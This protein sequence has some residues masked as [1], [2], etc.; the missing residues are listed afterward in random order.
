MKRILVVSDLHSGSR[1]GVMPEEVVVQDDLTGDEL[2]F[3]PKGGQLKLLDK[4]NR[5]IDDVGHVD[6]C[7]VNGDVC[8]GLQYRENGRTLWS[9]DSDVQAEA[10]KTLL[11][12][13]KCD[14]MLFTE[15]SGYHTGNNLPLDKVVAKSLKARFYG[16]DFIL[17]L[18]DEKARIHF[19][20]HVG[21]SKVFHYRTT[22]LARDAL[23][24][25]LNK[26]R[27]K[28]G[29]LDG[30]V[31]SHAH[32]VCG[33][34]YSTQ[35]AIITPAWQLRTPFGVRKGHWTPPDI[36]YT[37]ITANDDGSLEFQVEADSVT[38]PCPVVNG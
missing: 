34:F 24:M 8:D 16:M 29:R 18:K 15:G 20:H 22:P 21:V 31:R 23:L 37:L 11:E 4:W 19:A 28:Y 10:A 27:E 17:N 33:I 38:K 14:R 25:Y 2:D 1:Y 13:V 9:S 35:K 7:V 5:M 26:D 6:Y 30:I 3:V 36:G 32:Y 12:S